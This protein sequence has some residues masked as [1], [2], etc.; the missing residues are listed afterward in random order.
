[1]ISAAVEKPRRTSTALFTWIA[2][3]LV[4]SPLLYLL[5]I[6]PAGGLVEAGHL[7]RGRFHTLYMPVIWLHDQTLLQE[8]LEWYA[9]LW[10]W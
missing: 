9:A 7:M 8:P 1:V 5:S 10:G 3:V 4:A 2:A 6:G